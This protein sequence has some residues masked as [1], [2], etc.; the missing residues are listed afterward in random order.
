MEDNWDLSRAVGEGVGYFDLGPAVWW[1]LYFCDVAFVAESGGGWGISSI[2]TVSSLRIE[3]TCDDWLRSFVWEL[4][5]IVHGSYLED[6]ICLRSNPDGIGEILA[7]GNHVSILVHLVFQDYLHCDGENGFG[8]SSNWYYDRLGQ[9]LGKPEGVSF[10]SH[11][12]AI[13]VVIFIR[14]STSNL[15]HSCY[16]IDV[17]PDLPHPFVRVDVFVQFG[18][19][20]W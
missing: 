10:R 2:D 15:H 20:F 17:N 9:V 5:L 6:G 16:L 14:N 12:D 11:L 8:V 19:T 13:L 7:N 3:S 4:E 1:H 18:L